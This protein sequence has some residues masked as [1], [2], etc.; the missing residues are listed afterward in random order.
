[1]TPPD[2]PA[3]I[4][5]AAQQTLDQLGVRDAAALGELFSK[6]EALLREELAAIAN[7]GDANAVEAMRVRWLGRK[8]GV[9]RGITDNWLKSAPPELKRE[10]GQRLNALRPIETFNRYVWTK[11]AAPE[12][13]ADLGPDEGGGEI[14]DFSLERRLVEVKAI[15]D[16]KA[17]RPQGRGHVDRVVPG[18]GQIAGV[19]VGRVA[20]NQRD[21]LAG[22]GGRADTEKQEDDGGPQHGP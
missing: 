17:V 6:L 19:L 11:T 3:D 20:D 1:M 7:G 10:T 12:A 5:Q 22:M 16:L 9:I 4:A 13:Y 2:Y 21:A 14:A 8:Q 18:I 15:D